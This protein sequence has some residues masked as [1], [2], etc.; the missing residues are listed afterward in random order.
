MIDNYE[1]F[2]TRNIKAFYRRR[3]FSPIVYLVLLLLSWLI[4]PMHSMLVPQTVSNGVSF[5]N[6]YKNT[7][8]YVKLSFSELNFT[9]YTSEKRGTTEGYFYYGEYCDELVIVL[10][11]PQTCE[12]GLPTIKD[13]Q[14]TGKMV[15]RQ[16]SYSQL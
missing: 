5:A 12:E 13:I 2:I 10:L 15:K 8:R 1:H 14:V 3:L 9:G 11:S 4:L 7:D 16:H 6:I